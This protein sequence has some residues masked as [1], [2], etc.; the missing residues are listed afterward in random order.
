MVPPI[1]QRRP[2]ARQG[3][4]FARIIAEI[5]ASPRAVAGRLRGAAFEFVDRARCAAALLPCARAHEVPSDV[6]VRMLVRPEGERV[7]VLV[8]A[9]LE[10]MQDI[11]FPTFGPG[12]LDVPRAEQQLRDAAQLWLVDNLELYEGER[13]VPLAIVAVRAS[14]PS[15]RSFA[16]YESALAHLR[17]PPLP[18]GLDLAVAA[19]AARRRAR[20]ADRVGELAVLAERTD[21]AARHA[22]R[23]RRSLLRR[24]RRRARV[25]DRRGGRRRRARS[26]LA[27]IAAQVP[28]AGLRA[29]S[30]RRRSSVVPAVPRRAVSAAAAGAR[31]DRHGVHGRAFRH[32][33]RIGVW[34]GA[35]RAV[36]PAARRNADRAVDLLHGASRT[37]SARIRARAGR[38]RSASGSCTAS[39]SRSRCRTRC[40]SPAITC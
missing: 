2:V 35:E 25:P 26:A 20:S 21:A 22:R 40:S 33:D 6:T 31:V 38:S 4:F 14:I 34:A 1:R 24:E 10:A 3:L 29:H 18:A 7:K 12:Y 32:A 28:R 37:S 23:Q 13:R 36:V 5:G 19:G 39:A 15:D 27:S 30:R 16:E 17:A 11:T 9:P 8:R